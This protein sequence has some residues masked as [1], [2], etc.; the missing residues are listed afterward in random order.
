M[1]SFSP[2]FALDTAIVASACEAK[3]GTGVDEIY[4]SSRRV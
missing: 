1:L 2:D 3:T 4:D